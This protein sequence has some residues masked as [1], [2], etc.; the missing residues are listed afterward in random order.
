MTWD[1]YFLI[2]G[3]LLIINLLY[4]VYLKIDQ[5]KKENKLS[6]RLNRKYGR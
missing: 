3:S 2:F 5:V 6:E 1:I 4:L